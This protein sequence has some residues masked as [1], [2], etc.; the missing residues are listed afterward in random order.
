MRCSTNERPARPRHG[1]S[2][3]VRA[4]GLSPTPYPKFESFAPAARPAAAAAEAAAHPPCS[5]AAGAPAIAGTPAPSLWGSAARLCS[6]RTLSAVRSRA[7]SH[8][9]AARSTAVTRILPGRETA[10]SSRSRWVARCAADA[11]VLTRAPGSDVLAS[12]RAPSRPQHGSQA[13][14]GRSRAGSAACD[15]IASTRAARLRTRR[16]QAGR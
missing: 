14:S 11:P 7:R 13:T 3:G 5:S 10:E 12:A 6:R 4:C 2:S 16:T 1:S 9:R 8:R 15:V